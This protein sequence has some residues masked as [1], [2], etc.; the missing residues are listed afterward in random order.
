[1]FK[2]CWYLTPYVFFLL[3]SS[4]YN[5]IRGKERLLLIFLFHQGFQNFNAMLLWSSFRGCHCYYYSTHRFCPLPLKYGW[6]FPKKKFI[7][8]TFFEKRMGGWGGGGVK[9]VIKKRG[10]MIRSCPLL[11]V[12]IYIS[13]ISTQECGVLFSLIFIVCF[14]FY[15]SFQ[16]II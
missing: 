16:C 1:M 5:V 3:S 15:I 13:F 8:G 12:N 2:S 9:S 4:H 10:I 6:T 7:W 14:C 11:F